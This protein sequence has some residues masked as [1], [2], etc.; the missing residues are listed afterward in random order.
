[1]TASRGI[2]VEEPAAPIEQGGTHGF[3]WYTVY[4]TSLVAV[5]SQIDRGVLALFGEDDIGRAG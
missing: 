3:S 1:M 2:A 5:M 4:L